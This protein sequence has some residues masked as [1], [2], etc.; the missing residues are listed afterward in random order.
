MDKVNE[1]PFHNLSQIYMHNSH[2]LVPIGANFQ[3]IIPPML[4]ESA[5]KVK[6]R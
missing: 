3:V 6:S 5:Y 2:T 1:Q 4:S